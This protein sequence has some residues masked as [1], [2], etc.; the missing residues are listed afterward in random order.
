MWSPP[1]PQQKPLPQLQGRPLPS[2]SCPAAG[3]GRPACHLGSDHVCE[4]LCSQSSRL[5]LGQGR[6]GTPRKASGSWGRPLSP[7]GP[8]RAGKQA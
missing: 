7:E 4:W 2:L 3:L 8:D 6:S 1:S 5:A